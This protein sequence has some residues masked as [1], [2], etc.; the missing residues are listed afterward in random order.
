M[1]NPK[2][3]Q[4][5]AFNH[6][7]NSREDAAKRRACELPSWASSNSLPLSRR[8]PSSGGVLWCLLEVIIMALGPHY[9]GLLISCRLELRICG[10]RIC[11]PTQSRQ[12]LKPNK[13][14]V[15]AALHFWIPDHHSS[16]VVSLESRLGLLRQNVCLQYHS[17]LT[18]EGCRTLAALVIWTMVRSLE[19]RA[20]LEWQRSGGAV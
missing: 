5:L 4:G 1:H 20:I 7:P 13:R 16:W 3:E 12:H 18:S 14:S 10:E 17:Q 9:L 19:C 6:T 15:Q 2:E 11:K 8:V